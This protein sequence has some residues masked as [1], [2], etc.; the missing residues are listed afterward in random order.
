[1]HTFLLN[2][3]YPR[4]VLFPAL[5]LILA[6]CSAS[7]PTPS[8]HIPAPSP[9]PQLTMPSVPLPINTPVATTG[10]H[11]PS[12]IA[13]GSSQNVA[14]PAYSPVS[15]GSLT[16]M[17]RVHIPIGYDA[18]RALPLILVFHGYSGTAAQMER[19][20]GLS[21]L[22]D[23]HQ[24]L[25]VYGQGLPDGDGGP[26]MWASLGPLDH[27]LDDLLYVSDVLNDVQRTFCVDAH[28]IYATG[29]SNGGGMTVFLACRMAER[30]AD[31]AP[32]SANL[33]AIP[34]G[35]HPG[36]PIPLLYFHGSADPLLPYQGISPSLNPNWPLPSIQRWL[37]EWATRDG[38]TTGPVII[39]RQPTVTGEQW[40]NCAG[41]VTVVHY[42]L[43][44]AG[45]SM[46]TLIN[47]VPAM[48]VIWRFSRRYP[49]RS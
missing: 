16:R 37:Q 28:R 40:T 15:E 10:C 21:Q 25:V 48:E 24:F 30:I 22:A 34:G 45:H 19:A 23:R 14:I 13:P 29:F 4:M 32:M 18:V 44:E 47:G 31:F 20:T 17:Y 26:P 33:Y 38:C 1:M 49:L 5:L 46:P 42:R 11:L 27:G 2:R 7:V 8:Q 3:H 41:N 6:A 39:L 36:R 35:C 12:A 9:S 43:E